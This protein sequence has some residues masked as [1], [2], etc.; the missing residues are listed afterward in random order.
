MY[1][2]NKKQLKVASIVPTENLHF[3]QWSEAW[4]LCL[5][6]QMDFPADLALVHAIQCVTT[7]ALSSNIL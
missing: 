4:R 7:P 6:Q 5:I 3:C 1:L 2:L